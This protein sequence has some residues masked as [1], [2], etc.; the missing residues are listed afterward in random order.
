MEC[1]SLCCTVDPSQIFLSHFFKY[2]YTFVVVILY[3][4]FSVI[5]KTLEV[6]SSALWHIEQDNSFVAGGC[7][8][9]CRMF[10]STLGLYSLDVN[11]KSSP[12]HLHCN[13]HVFGGGGLVIKLCPILAIH[14]LLPARILCPW[15]SPGKNTGVGCHLLLQGIFLTQ[16][17]DPSPQHCRQ[18]IYQLSYK[19][20]LNMS[21]HVAKWPPGNPSG[22]LSRL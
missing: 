9:Y 10:S 22:P 11:G 17:L 5:N 21:L 14:G 19:R 1:S 2:A 6:I 3:T 12:P 13:K 8:E 18:M 4:T 16:E 15:D 7:P 20:S